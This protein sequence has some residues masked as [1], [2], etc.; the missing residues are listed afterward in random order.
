MPE[1]AGSQKPNDLLSMKR[2]FID[3]LP[4]SMKMSLKPSG[5]NSLLIFAIGM[6][7]FLV[8]GATAGVASPSYDNGDN[9]DPMTEARLG[10]PTRVQLA[11]GGQ[12]LQDVVIGHE[13]ESRTIRAAED[14][15]SKLS[16]IT[17]GEFRV[18]TGDGSTGLAVG[19]LKDFP[20]LKF[21][22]LFKPDDPTR[23]DEHLL[24][25]HGSGVYLV[26]ATAH[27]AQNAV[28]TFLQ[29]LG[30]RQFF[31]TGTWEIIPD[32][33]NLQASIRTLEKPSFYNRNGPRPTS[34]TD[35]VVWQEWRERNRFNN[36]FNISTGHAY[37]AIIRRNQEEFD[38][39]PEYLSSNKFRVSEPGLVE[40]VVQDAVNQ[41]HDNPSM[42]SI[43]MDPS[44]GGGWAT[45][46][47]EMEFLPHISDR[48]VYL[49]NKVAEAIND[50]GYGEKF[51]GIYAYNQHSDPPTIDVHPNVIVSL[52]T[53]Y[54]FTAYSIE[55]LADL[56]GERGA[57]VGIR[58]FYDTFVHNQGLPRGGRGGNV[59][60]H[61]SKLPEWHEKGVRLVRG[62][63]TD[64][65]AVNGLGFYVATQLQWNVN[66]DAEAIVQ[67]FLV[68]SFGDAYEPMKAF[69]DMVGRG[70]DR[71]RTD[72]D[73]LYHMYKYIK[74][75]YEL[76]DDPDVIARLNE[77]ALYTRYCE[78]WLQFGGQEEAQ[79]TYR[80]AYRMQSVMMSPVNQ[81]YR[82]LRRSRVNATVPRDIHPG[83]RY[84]VG[85]ELKDYEGWW[86]SDPFTQAEIMGYVTD[87]VVNHQ[88][89]DLDFPVLE[90]DHDDLE[91]VAGRIELP[92]VSTGTIGRYSSSRGTNRAFTWLEEG[93]ELRLQVRGGTI[94][95][96]R[97]DLLLFLTSPKEATTEDVDF[98]VVPNDTEWHEVVMTSPY[99]GIH[100]LSWSDG[101]D[102]T[103]LRWE[104]GQPMTLH[105]GLRG[106]YS[107]QGRSSMYFYVPKGTEVVGGYMSH[108]SY[109]E[110]RAADGTTI[111]DW[112]NPD[113]ND[114]YFSIPVEEGQDGGLWRIY[115]HKGYT[116]RLLSVPPYMARNAEELLLPIYVIEGRAAPPEEEEQ[117]VDEEEP[118]SFELRQNYPNPFNPSTRIQYALPH[119]MHVRLDV[120]NIL[121]QRVVTLLN[122]E[123]AAGRHEVTFDA[124]GLANGMYIY[125][126]QGDSFTKVR[127][128]LLVK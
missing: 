11:S 1:F 58:D 93:Q 27:G 24:V 31:P 23:G 123:K 57:V 101:S 65:W 113:S 44:D 88:P 47:Q 19:T 67:D 17:G 40:L 84:R 37:A 112:R 38:K 55:Q 54:S 87:G 100:E 5:N 102:R 76:T 25:S 32:K 39:H 16:E 4:N 103:H 95:G 119:Q 33:P 15:A 126:L 41:F 73:L 45:D 89:D 128:M 51:V 117:E 29:H 20:N 71:P 86:V 114:G 111:E 116:L 125:R 36:S 77:L 104:E 10:G 61:K 79:A 60:Y 49:A 99:S 2:L 21:H 72:S 115:N 122:E 64:A 75:G 56:W 66:A 120:F 80:H 108:Q 26:G 52:A 35:E 110:I 22:S 85:M 6:A 53:S 94:F 43:S 14:L 91:P 121:G 74:K 127:Q 9:I 118:E 59:N 82:H 124:A 50:L 97:G 107:F 105:V 69:Y 70:R 42:N 46:E 48:V 3:L 18:R 81:L 109:G 34:W 7:Y 78:L 12:A 62:N 98:A 92:E 13:A 8:V 96:D 68:K 30:Y 83:N 28:W 63:S 90:F 106:A